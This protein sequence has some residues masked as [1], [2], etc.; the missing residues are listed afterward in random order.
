MERNRLQ[1]PL[2]ILSVIV[3]L[4]NDFYLKQAYGNAITGKLSDFA[5]LLAF[6]FFFSCLLPNWKK[7]IHI[8]TAILFIWWKSSFSQFF[9]DG[10]N[11]AGIPIGRVVDFSDN[12]A[13]ISILI[14]YFILSKKTEYKNIK[15]ALL[16]SITFVSSFAFIATSLPPQTLE[17]YTDVNKVYSF[18]KPIDEFIVDFNDLQ[19]KELKLLDKHKITYQFNPDNGTYIYPETGDTLLRLVTLG[20]NRKDTIHINSYFANYMIYENTDGNTTLVLKN[21][22][23]IS[24]NTGLLGK[25]FPGTAD[26][27]KVRRFQKKS[28]YIDN[29]KTISAPVDDRRIIV[30]QDTISKNNKLIKE[31]EKRI[32]KKIK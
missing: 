5:G 20:E 24:E 16:Y 14:S 11:W 22:F 15:P 13:L 17:S 10:V 3:L 31:F 27:A 29:I 8:L 28:A 4:F 18:E 1:H 25:I 9:I 30:K 2:F 21:I 26:I 32:I 6:P 19:K 23:N 12:M 7:H